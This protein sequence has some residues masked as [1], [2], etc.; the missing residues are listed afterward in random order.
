VVDIPGAVLE[1]GVWR[2][3]SGALM[4]SRLKGLGV[5]DP[6]FLCDTWTGVVKTGPLDT[7]YYDGK[8]SDTSRETVE[9]LLARMDLPNVT[10]LHGV[11]PEE[12]GQVIADQR[13]RLCHIDVD[14]YQSAHDVFEWAWPRLSV[15]GIVVFD[16]YG[17]PATP[18]VTRLVEQQ[19]GLPDRLLFHNLNGHGIIVKR[20]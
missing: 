4:A 17:C 13:L 12:T 6:V 8:H 19:R 9:A 14:V 15:G 2:G 16:D 18:G 7:Y 10:L 3:G 20:S 5:E 1:V 11:F